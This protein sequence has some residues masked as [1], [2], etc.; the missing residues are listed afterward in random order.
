MSSLLGVSPINRFY[1]VRG[2]LFRETARLQKA[3]WRLRGQNGLGRL[4]LLQALRKAPRA[5]GRPLFGIPCSNKGVTGAV[6]HTPGTEFTGFCTNF[7][8]FGTK[9]RADGT[10]NASICTAFWYAKPCFWYRNADFRYELCVFSSVG[11]ELKPHLPGW[12]RSGHSSS[13]TFLLRQDGRS[14][15]VICWACSVPSLVEAGNQP[16]CMLRWHSHP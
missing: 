2:L 6:L 10:K 8:H 13:G 4:G 16:S 5:S 11:L 3:P 7:G 12:G 14:D 15:G 9:K 1:K